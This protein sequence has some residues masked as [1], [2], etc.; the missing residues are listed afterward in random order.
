MDTIRWPEF[1]QAYVPTM[2]VWVS[3]GA[4]LGLSKYSFMSAILQ[5]IFLL[6]WTYSGHV[7]AHM[8]SSEWPFNVLNPHVYIHH[9]KAIVLNRT[10]ELI[11]EAIV[12]FSSFF[13]I[14]IVQW[15]SGIYLF[16]TTM[17]LYSAF[18]YIAIHILD[19]SLFHNEDHKQHHENSFCNYEPEFM[20]ILFKTRCNTEKPY[21]NMIV[22]IPHAI[23]AFGLAYILQLTLQLD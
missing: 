20:D 18:L 5:S 12:N 13:I 14:I 2:F 8:V 9:N 1:A 4:L 3:L 15:L 7:L 22:E 11:V 6:I 17:V 19:Y 10:L 16:S 23:L 21:R